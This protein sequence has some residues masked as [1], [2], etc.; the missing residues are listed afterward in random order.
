MSKYGK[1]GL[2]DVY[3]IES[4]S[5]KEKLSARNMMVGLKMISDSFESEKKG[6]V[7][8]VEEDAIYI[9]TGR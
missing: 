5:D 8:M 9:S 6:K 2:M 1:S 4:T 3:R 7:K